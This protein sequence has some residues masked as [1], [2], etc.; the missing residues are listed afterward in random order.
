MMIGTVAAIGAESGQQFLYAENKN[1]YEFFN[2]QYVYLY[3]ECRYGEQI[4]LENNTP[5]THEQPAEKYYPFC[6]V[7][8]GPGT[9]PGPSAAIAPVY[10]SLP[11]FPVHSLAAF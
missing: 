4:Q 3:R 1:G 6:F 9:D 5:K 7:H 2:I 11:V 10:R 8:P